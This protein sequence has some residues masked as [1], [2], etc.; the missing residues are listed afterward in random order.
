MTTENVAEDKVEVYDVGHYEA[1]IDILI[2]EG[3]RSST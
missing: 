2:P 1:D 3:L